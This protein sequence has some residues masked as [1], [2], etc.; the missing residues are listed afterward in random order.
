MDDETTTI[1]SAISENN[2]EDQSYA[3][4]YNYER[5]NSLPELFRDEAHQ[6]AWEKYWAKNGERLIWQS[7]I[8]KYIEYINPEYLDQNLSLLGIIECEQQSIDSQKFTQEEAFTFEPPLPSPPPPNISTEIVISSP[9]KQSA[10]DLM[11]QGWNQLTPD[12]LRYL[13]QNSNETDNF[14]LSPRCDSI[15]SSIPFTIGTTDSMTNVTRMTISSY[16]FESSHV[17]SESTSSSPL[18]EGNSNKVSSFSD[19]EYDTDNQMATTRA[20]YECEKILMENKPAEHLPANDKNSEDYWQK[21]W[22]NHAQEQYVK[23]YN[24]F[25]ETHRILQEE[26]S[27][28]FKSDS[29]FLPGE[30]NVDCG[31]KGGG[32]K[33]RK[34]SGRKKGSHSLQRLVANLNMKNDLAKFDT[35]QKFTNIPPATTDA[36]NNDS[37][38]HHEQSQSDSTI[39]DATETTLMASMGLPTSFGRRENRGS[40]NGGGDDE[41]PDERSVNLKRSHEI[42]TEDHALASNVDHIKS[43]FEMM[44]YAFIDNNN[45]SNECETTSMIIT[46]GEIVY[47]KKHVR[48]HNRMLKM[49]TSVSRPRHTYFDDDGNEIVEEKEQEQE[50]LLHSSSDED[51]PLIQLPTNRANSSIVPFT[52]QLSSDGN[53]NDESEIPEEQ[54]NINLSI[55]QENDYAEDPIVVMNDN[56]E[57]EKLQSSAKREKKKKRKGKFQTI[58]PVEIANDKI[59]KKYWYKRFS[60]FSMFDQGI[61]LDRGEFII[62]FLVI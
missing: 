48:L 40:G 23:H 57:E 53:A 30:K 16:G 5:N 33:R 28:S 10:E 51:T 45:K 4:S 17:T 50:N 54:V 38:N 55:D 43:Q 49:F 47:R 24:T 37:H 35:S 13:H 62:I 21:R 61:Q 14:L 32:S 42:E 1:K 27:S 15:N 20:A 22:Q 6:Q 60:L 25:M 31:G 18:E 3:K 56:V 44:G 52:S 46:K 12:S 41:P 39:I 7:W 36:D 11:I 2:K 9:A 29:G 19:S 59:L 58:I 8:E 34:K 26:M